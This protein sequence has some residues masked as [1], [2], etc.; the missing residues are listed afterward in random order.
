MD[1]LTKSELIKQA[2]YYTPSQQVTVPA[3]GTATATFQGYN[4]NLY[5]LNRFLIGGSSLS[6]IL[7]TAQMKNSDGELTL[8]KNIQL[9]V[10]Q[11]LF[12]S[13][14]LRGAYPI[15]E[16][17]LLDLTFTNTSG[18]DID[19]NMELVGYSKVQLENLKKKYECNNAIFPKPIFIYAQQSIAASATD[20]IVKVTLP[21]SKLR[22]Y[23]MALKSDSDAD[24]QVKIR[25][26]RTY[27]KPLVYLSQI[28]DE[29]KN[30]DI[31][32]PIDLDPTTPFELFVTN[33][34][35]VNAHTVSFLAETYKV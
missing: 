23:R 20:S 16:Q 13:H 8:F 19:V 7:V 21:A 32:L 29:F 28:N 1:I 26:N 33:L 18:A 12:L 22:L 14:S 35:G 9:N 10:L 4:G 25:H 5:G 17:T 24:I 2:V 3:N 11:E 30:L 31:I 34:D 15:E 6:S 27:I